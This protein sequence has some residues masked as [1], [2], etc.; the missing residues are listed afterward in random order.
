MK[1]DA[2]QNAMQAMEAV[3]A[4]LDGQKATSLGGA[5][6]SGG[7]ADGLSDAIEA[8]DAQQVQADMSLEMLMRGE[9]STAQTMTALSEADIAL[10]TMASVRDKVVQAYEQ[11]LNMAI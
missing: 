1:V 6:E 5:S 9:G 2:I 7:F 10:R 3:Q 8:V 11:I 4:Q